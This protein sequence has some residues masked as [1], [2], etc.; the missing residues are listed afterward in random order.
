MKLAHE[1]SHVIQSAFND[2]TLA[3]V[4]KRSGVLEED[5]PFLELYDFIKTKDGLYGLSQ[6]EAYAQQNLTTGN[7][8]TVTMEDIS[9][10]MGSYLLGLEYFAYRAMNT[11]QN[12]GE[13]EIETLALHL[14][15]T[16]RVWKNK[17]SQS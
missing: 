2:S 5:R 14:E 16:L 9:E 1:I 13:E 12:L 10:A 4:D 17:V 3:H 8:D 15:K 11:R 7:Y 6:E